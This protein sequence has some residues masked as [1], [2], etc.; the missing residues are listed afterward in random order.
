MTGGARLSRAL[1]GKRGWVA[2]GVLLLL[3]LLALLGRWDT[4]RRRA[5]P[6]LE[7]AVAQADDSIFTVARLR[8]WLDAQPDSLSREEVQHWL[9]GWVED[10]IL[11]QAAVRQGLDTL[12]GVREELKRLR[13]RYLRGLLEEQSLAESLRISTLELKTWARANQ[14]LLALPERQLRF[15]W[16]AGADSLALARLI[17]VIQRDQLTRKRLEDQRLGSG[18]TEFVTRG[19][20]PLAH[21]A[22]LLGLKLHQA[23]PVLRGPEGWMVYQ[24]EEVRP[25]GWVPDPDQHEELVRAAML[26]DLRWKRLQ[27]RLE[28]LRQEAVWKVDLTPLLEVEIGVPPAR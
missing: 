3:A 8:A 20:L 19:E 27:S 5:R 6:D 11:Y 2:L 9:E 22:I 28:T 4:H 18:R 12:G 26:Q 16:V 25:V 21:A 15:S 23:S 17:P 14:D 10:Q 24:L 1:W 13:L 7:R